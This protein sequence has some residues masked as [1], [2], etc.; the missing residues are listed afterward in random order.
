MN[1]FKI[2]KKSK[3]NYDSYYNKNGS[4]WRY[5]GAIDKVNNIIK[6]CNNLLKIILYF[7]KLI[8]IKCKN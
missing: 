3:L 6:L 8:K 2:S 1:E 5:I 7:Y 4:A